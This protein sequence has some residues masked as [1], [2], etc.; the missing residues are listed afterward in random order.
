MLNSDQVT[1]Y[2]KILEDKADSELGDAKV[3]KDAALL[4]L[5][6]YPHIDPNNTEIQANTERLIFEAFKDL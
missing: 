1:K 4:M 5:R 2:T 6:G 3:I